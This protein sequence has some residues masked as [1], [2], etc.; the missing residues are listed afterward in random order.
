[1]TVYKF[2]P[3]D[4][5][6][7]TVAVQ[8]EHSTDDIMAQ[9]ICQSRAMDGGYEGRVFAVGRACASNNPSC[10]DIC[11]SSQLHEQDW[12]GSQYTWVTIGAFYVYPNRP[13]TNPGNLN[14]TRLNLDSKLCGVHSFPSPLIVGQTIAA[15]SH[16]FDLQ[17][18]NMM[19][20][21]AL[22]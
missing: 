15:A 6:E 10:T 3:Q 16:Y 18:L 2:S 12:G 20:I 19:A 13:A 7:D 1:M 14:Q 8:E 11:A 9:S 4:F 22:Y 21:G 5:S 17:E